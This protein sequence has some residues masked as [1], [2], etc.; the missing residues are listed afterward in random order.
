MALVLFVSATLSFTA[1]S[2]DDNAPVRNTTP[3]DGTWISH[4]VAYV[5][6]DESGNEVHSG[7]NYNLEQI[8]F[9]K[10]PVTEEVFEIKGTDVTLTELTKS[11][12]KI[13]T[14]GTLKDDIIKFEGNKKEEREIKATTPRLILSYKMYIGKMEGILT[15]SYNK[16]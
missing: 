14:K 13:S 15:T 6:Y 10:D 12:K 3:A 8:P 4:K 5:A 9:G 16:N 11:G 2:S 7:E 1:C